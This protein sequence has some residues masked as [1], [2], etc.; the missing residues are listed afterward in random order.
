[1]MHPGQQENQMR[2]QC[3]LDHLVCHEIPT[4]QPDRKII[5]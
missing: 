1:M 5:T 4:T 3:G 2:N